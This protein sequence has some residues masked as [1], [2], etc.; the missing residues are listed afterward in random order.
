MS[1][2]RTERSF[3]VSRRRTTRR[4]W[5]VIALATVALVAFPSCGGGG[6][7]GGSTGGGQPT[8][9]ASGTAATQNLVTLAGAPV[10]DNQLSLSVN[11]TGP[12]TENV[13]GFAFDLLLANG[14]VVQQVLSAAAGGTLPTAGGGSWSAVAAKS[15]TQRITV[16]VSKMGGTCEAFAAGTTKIA[17]ILIKTQTGSTTIK[18]VGATPSVS[19]TD[20]AACGADSCVGGKLG[21]IT[22]DSVSGTIT[23]P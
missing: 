18:F 1:F 10:T 3:E 16:G 15:G 17:T 22:F 2:D 14:A 12:S 4:D 6:G 9:T 20:A 5:G 13:C 11:Y 23:Q 7:G 8:F 21:S 19:A